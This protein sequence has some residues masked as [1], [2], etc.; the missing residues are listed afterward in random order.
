MTQIMQG[1]TQPH[2]YL[3]RTW[4][5]RDR[6]EGRMQRP[7]Q[8]QVIKKKLQGNLS[9][10]LKRSVSETKCCSICNGQSIYTELSAL[11]RQA[12]SLR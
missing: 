3:P 9:V 8:S 4:A 11:D 7:F 5:H 10:C 1:L 6:L 12:F 2:F